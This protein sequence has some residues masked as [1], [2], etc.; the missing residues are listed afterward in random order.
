MM[1]VGNP[2]GKRFQFAELADR[3]DAAQIESGVLRKLLD[4]SWKISG[5]W[6]V[7]SGRLVPSRRL[8]PD[9]PLESLH[10]IETLPL[11]LAAPA[12]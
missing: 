5:Q 8:H 10:M 9:S 2:G 7:A 11:R 4:P 6:S 12:V 3:R 1:A